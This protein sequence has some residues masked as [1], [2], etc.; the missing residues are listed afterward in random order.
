[1]HRRARERARIDRAFRVGRSYDAADLRRWA[2]DAR[3]RRR[4][5]TLAY[6]RVRAQAEVLAELR[7]AVSRRFVQQAGDE[8]ERALLYGLPAVG[9]TYDPHPIRVRDTVAEMRQDMLLYGEGWLRIC[10]PRPIRA[11]MPVVDAHLVTPE[12]LR[13]WMGWS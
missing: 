4:T 13:I 2:A 5:P 3:R 6:F 8:L 11:A 10:V 7:R 12:E 9:L 1:M